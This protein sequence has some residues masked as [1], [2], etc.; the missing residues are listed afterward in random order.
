[1]SDSKKIP[2]HVAIIMDGN[3]RW[4]KK[5]GLPK[6][7]GHRA[8]ARSVDE[9]TAAAAK[10]GVKVLTLYAFST[11]NWKRPKME[12][13]GLFRLLEKHLKKEEAR[14]NKNNIKLSVVGDITAL[15]AS[16]QKLIRAVM[17][18]TAGN[19]GMVLNIA[20]NYGSR[21]EMLEAVRKLAKDAAAG[22]ISPEE[23]DE[24][25]FSSSLYTKNLPDPDL[26]IRTSGEKRISNFLLWQLSYAEFYFTEKLWPDFREADF[27][28]AVREY[29]RRERRYGG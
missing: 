28:K 23:I 15:P 18:S 12:V 9:I 20:L 27:K 11:E 26:L 8:G 10:L 5:R 3:G 16:T 25:L 19:T 21:A 24:K 6:L 14:L 1:M 22:A 17:G 2:Q 29:G 4:A 13:E 7:A